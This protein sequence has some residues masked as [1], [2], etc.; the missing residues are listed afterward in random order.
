MGSYLTIRLGAT[1]EITGPGGM[2]TKRQREDRE[3]RCTQARE[4]S[5]WRNAWPRAR[6]LLLSA[7]LLATGCASSNRFQFANESRTGSGVDDYLPPP[8][9]PVVP[10]TPLPAPVGV[11]GP[12]PG[13]IGYAEPLQPPVNS[14]PPPI[15]DAR[16]LPIP[17]NPNPNNTGVNNQRLLGQTPKAGEPGSQLS[18]AAD[19]PE[20]I[21]RVVNSFNQP[22]AGVSIQ[23]LDIS[24]GRRVAVETASRAD[25]GFRVRNLEYGAQYELQAISNNGGVRLVG[26][27][28]AVVPDTAV[29]I[30]ILPEDSRTYSP[31]GNRLSSVAQARD[32]VPTIPPR[33]GY[34]PMNSSSALLPTARIP[35]S[36]SVNTTPMLD[37]PLVVPSSNPTEQFRRA[38][39]LPY[40]QVTPDA[41]IGPPLAESP[42]SVAKDDSIVTDAPREP[43]LYPNVPEESPP[44]PESTNPKLVPPPR[45]E[46]QEP[47][48]ST[49][50]LRE[51]NAVAFAGT[52]LATATLFTP[53]LQERSLG[54]LK[55]EL[56]LLD[57]FGSWCGPCRRAVPKLNGLH[58]RYGEQGLWVIGVACEHGDAEEAAKQ[59]ESARRELAIEYPVLV[60]PM[61]E[62]SAVR[63]YFQVTKY[64]TLV[65][66]TREGKVLFEGTG[67]DPET[68]ARL[69]QAIR[70]GVSELAVQPR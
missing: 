52:S 2:V 7:M 14:G 38:P 6:S 44:E 49:A 11:A 18:R 42:N 47:R 60:S 58:R 12:L 56:I 68:I 33:P 25:G 3:R 37:R 10:A 63:D 53:S 22:V 29:V 45:E 69:E 23:V 64:P 27:A 40:A 36:V 4:R 26:S 51:A 57:F 13:G 66:L 48:P 15:A 67:G 39:S 41:R 70:Q 59:A 43:E 17:A 9:E 55:G 21:G 8:R 1:T 34:P 24:R 32:A 54:E 19:G 31:L 35:G 30:Q 62:P 20:L 65:L 61:D 28:I 46:P 16:P 5:C 50:D